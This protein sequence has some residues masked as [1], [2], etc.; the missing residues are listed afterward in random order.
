[1]GTK[2]I[3]FVYLMFQTGL[4]KKSQHDKN[5]LFILYLEVKW[6]FISEARPNDTSIALN[7]SDKPVLIEL[8]MLELYYYF[9]SIKP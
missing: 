4:A 8:K 9:S 2:E 3:R 6:K 1:M 7:G 5:K